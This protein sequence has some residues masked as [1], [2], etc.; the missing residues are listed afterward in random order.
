MRIGGLSCN[1]GGVSQWSCE[2]DFGACGPPA[3][4]LPMAPRRA[5]RTA[6]C[7]DGLPAAARVQAVLPRGAVFSILWATAQLEAAALLWLCPT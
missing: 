2:A 4:P 3:Q 1:A 7:A 6:G 5:V